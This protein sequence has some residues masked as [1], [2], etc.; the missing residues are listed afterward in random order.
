[1]LIKYFKKSIPVINFLGLGFFS[2][3]EQVIIIANDW[4]GL[5]PPYW[6]WANACLLFGQV[7]DY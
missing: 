2:S 4:L 6:F 7:L 5:S 1:M 3:A